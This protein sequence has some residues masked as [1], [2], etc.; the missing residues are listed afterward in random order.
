MDMTYCVPTPKTP[1][2]PT[3][4]DDRLRV[5]TLFNQAN[6]EIDDIALQLN[7]TRRQVEYALTHR[8]TPQKHR[9]GRHLLLNTPK[10]KALISWVCANAENRRVPWPDIPAIL[11]W[12]CRLT[13][14]Q[15][16]FKKEG[17][18]RRFARQKPPISEKDRLL[19]LQWAQEHLDWG[20]E[21]DNILWSDE[22]WVQP[23]THKRQRIT[24]K[25]GL[26][27]VY[28]PDCVI[29][30][31]QR[32]IGWMF[33]GCISGRYGKGFGVFWEKEWYINPLILIQS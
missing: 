9:S 8:L 2:H 10:R 27:E 5:Q 25:I 26:S 29:T 4:R 13:A 30:K 1:T 15:S 17:Y 22:S 18:V 23:G 11:G 12:D 19:R 6:W 33:W 24:R 28:H 32:K 3:S 14:I 16:A 31:H 20:E 21:W 7:L